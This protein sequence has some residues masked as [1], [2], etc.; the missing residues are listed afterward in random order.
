MVMKLDDDSL[1]VQTD[2]DFRLCIYPFPI[3]RKQ[4]TVDLH[5][6][7]CLC[8]LFHYTSLSP[9]VMNYGLLPIPIHK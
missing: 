8:S 3:W 4:G 2:I 9:A 6:T 7:I 1:E 5:N